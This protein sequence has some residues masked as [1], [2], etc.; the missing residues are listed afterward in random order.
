MLEELN[1]RFKR[2]IGI[3]L[4]SMALVTFTLFIPLVI[5]SNFVGERRDTRDDAITDISQSWSDSLTLAGPFIIVPFVDLRATGETGERSNI[6][7]AWF[8]PENL[9]IS[10]EVTPE[11]RYRSIYEV[12]VYSASLDLA[13]SFAAPDF[14]GWNVEPENILWDEARLIFGVTDMRGIRQSVSLSWG[15]E[16][17]SFS[18]GIADDPAAIIPTGISAAI[19]AQQSQEFSFALELNG[20]HTLDFLPV[21]GE[22]YVELSSPWPDPS[23]IG[24]FL[25][26][27]REITEDGFEASWL[28]LDLNRPYGQRWR[29][30]S[31]DLF[32]SAFGLS[33]AVPV[34]HYLKV[35]RSTRY[36]FLVIVLTLLSFFL[37]ELRSRKRA[38]AFQ[39]IL[40]GLALCLFYL[41]LLSLSEHI[42]FDWAYVIASVATIGLIA[43]YVRA[44]F[45]DSTLG[46]VSAVVLTGLYGFV[47]L[48]LQLEDYALLVGSIGLF[49]L[50]ALTMFL[51]RNF[52]E[53]TGALVDVEPNASP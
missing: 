47:F 20:S 48:L 5:I 53:L 15:D 39:Y 19:D 50:L 11:I 7:Y 13:G 28:V 40:I 22:T 14:S 51:T 10:G 42:L 46:G 37:I 38:H 41:L 34:D 1:S 21:G 23:F 43:L 16:E 31:V 3:K 9:E 33:L 25:P 32:G 2:S 24:A 17:I 27:E 35:R 4:L 36:A 26:D 12:A 8:L 44:V 49:L 45:A 18:S 30:D 6:R 52:K 29:D